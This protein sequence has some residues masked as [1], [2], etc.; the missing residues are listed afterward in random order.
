M[1][2]NGFNTYWPNDI[3]L[4]PTKR[5]FLLLSHIVCSI[6]KRDMGHNKP[7]IWRSAFRPE[8]FNLQEIRRNRF[9]MTTVNPI[10]VIGLN[11]PIEKFD[12]NKSTLIMTVWRHG[13]WK[14]SVHIKL[15]S[16]CNSQFFRKLCKICFRSPKQFS[17][18]IGKVSSW[19]YNL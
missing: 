7:T 17:H 4:T 8:N 12:L 5:D 15:S 19:N 9:I 6:Q 18:T 16:S 3:S 13:N 11:S 14:G 10:S 2:E 1:F